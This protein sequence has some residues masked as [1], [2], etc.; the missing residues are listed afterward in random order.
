MPT[1]LRRHIPVDMVCKECGTN[2]QA[3]RTRVK[4]GQGTFCTYKCYTEWYRKN[5]SPEFRGYSNGKVY[6][7]G[8]KWI[9]QWRD[10]SNKAHNTSYARWWWKENVGDIPEGYGVSYIDGNSENIDPSNFECIPMK[11]ILGKGAKKNTGVPKPSI[12]GENNKWWKGG[13]NYEYPLTFS[14]SLKRKIKTRDSYTCQSCLCVFDSRS[15]DV[16]HKDRNKN[17]NEDHN[18]ISL[19]KSCH[20]AVHGKESKTNPTILELRS[21]LG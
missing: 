17:N 16:H 11:V 21:L 15:L 12:A 3:P 6:K 9:Y 14:K 8:K 1:K 4:N 13:K 19:C 5:K 18:L 10:D 20:R 7:V 2:Y